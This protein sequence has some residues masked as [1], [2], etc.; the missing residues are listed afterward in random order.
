MGGVPRIESD[1]YTNL[2]LEGDLAGGSRSRDLGMVQWR[3]QVTVNYNSYDLLYM[4]G[5]PK[6]NLCRIQVSMYYLL[7]WESSKGLSFQIM[8]F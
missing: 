2:S 4:S 5:S 8:A 1:K 7:K 3:H 6:G